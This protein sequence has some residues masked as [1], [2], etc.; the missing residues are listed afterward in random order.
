MTTLPS[1]VITPPTNT[2]SVRAAVTP[3]KLPP[4]AEQT[5]EPQWKV[6]IDCK[7]EQ[8]QAELVEAFAYRGL[9]FTAPS[10]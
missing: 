5:A 8:Q 3:A 2:P 7:D 10:M 4:P 1:R 6:I 9:T